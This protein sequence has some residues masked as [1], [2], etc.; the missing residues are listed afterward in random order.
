M[1]RGAWQAI[2][3]RVTKNQRQLKLLSART[4][5]HAHMRTRTHT[6]RYLFYD[7]LLNWQQVFH[8][9]LY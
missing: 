6:H 2:V 7:H 3:H 5:A 1:D 9:L 8:S 4:R